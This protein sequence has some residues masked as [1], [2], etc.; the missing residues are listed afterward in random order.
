MNRRKIV[1][2]VH[3]RKKMS[4]GETDLEK[5]TEIGKRQRKGNS[6]LK[7]TLNNRTNIKKKN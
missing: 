1:T 2:N 4:K 5:G 3:E 7:T 6:N